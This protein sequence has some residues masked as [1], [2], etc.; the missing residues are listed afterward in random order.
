MTEFFNVIKEGHMGCGHCESTI[1]A[2]IISY[3]DNRG[4]ECQTST[5]YENK[6]EAEEICQQLNWAFRMGN[7]SKDAAPSNEYWGTKGK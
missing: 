7:K 3:T 1:P 2:Y 4:T 5:T 6:D